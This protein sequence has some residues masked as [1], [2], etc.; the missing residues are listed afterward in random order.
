MVWLSTSRRR[1][2]YSC[3]RCRSR[4]LL[5]PVRVVQLC[6]Q[7]MGSQLERLGPSGY[8]TIR[9]LPL[10]PPQLLLLPPLLP[11]LLLLFP[12]LPLWRV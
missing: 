1:R 12:P 6:W 5:R 4:A 11:P 7:P 3:R 8:C 2:Q 9:V 10:L